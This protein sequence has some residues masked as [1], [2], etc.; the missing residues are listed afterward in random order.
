MKKRVLKFEMKNAPTVEDILKC[1]NITPEQFE[2]LMNCLD[3]IMTLDHLKKKNIRECMPAM[4][5]KVFDLLLEYGVDGNIITQVG[6]SKF[7]K[8]EK[9]DYGESYSIETVMVPDLW[10]LPNVTCAKIFYYTVISISKFI[11]FFKNLIP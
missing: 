1:E 10:Y 6:R 9:G 8:Y 5:N 11:L 3:K 4:S 2:S 7:K